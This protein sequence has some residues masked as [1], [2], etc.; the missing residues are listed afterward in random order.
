[1]KHVVFTCIVA[2]ATAA[3]TGCGVDRANT[4]LLVAVGTPVLSP[5]RAHRLCVGEANAAYDRAL[6]EFEK[7]ERMSLYRTRESNAFQ[8]ERQAKAAAR[9]RYSACLS[10]SGYRAVY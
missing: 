7:R 9:Q 3:L 6:Q 4:P 8:K 2:A 1:M 10:A 5:D